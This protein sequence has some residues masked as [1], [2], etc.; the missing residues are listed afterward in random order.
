[1][2]EQRRW[3]LLR[4]APDR[5]ARAPLCNKRQL[6]DTDQLTRISQLNM[7]FCILVQVNDAANALCASY[8]LIKQFKVTC[9]RISDATRAMTCQRY[10]YFK[11]A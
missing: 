1:M 3:R 9:L 5:A 2:R 4:A 10:T 8:A 7:W 11:I 6:R